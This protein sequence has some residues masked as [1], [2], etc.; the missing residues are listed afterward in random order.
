[1]GEMDVPERVVRS[2][3]SDGSGVI[4]PQRVG[5]VADGH[6]EAQPRR[7]PLAGSPSEP[8]PPVPMPLGQSTRDRMHGA[9]GPGIDVALPSLTRERLLG[10]RHQVLAR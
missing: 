8:A 2:R 3:G 6:I 7:Y 1:M 5:A 10:S 9:Y 4:V